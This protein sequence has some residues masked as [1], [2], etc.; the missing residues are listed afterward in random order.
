MYVYIYI[1]TH[2]YV[3]LHISVIFFY[4][5]SELIKFRNFSIGLLSSDLISVI[6]LIE[7][8]MVINICRFENASH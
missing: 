8:V 6:L 5:V 7:H 1:Y 2:I 4:S 3:Y